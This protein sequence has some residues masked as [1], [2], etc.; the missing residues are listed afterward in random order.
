MICIVESA[1]DL[2]LERER[3]RLLLDTH[4]IL[5]GELQDSRRTAAAGFWRPDT[6]LQVGAA[7]QS[8][9]EPQDRIIVVLLLL[10]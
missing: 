7:R 10:G 8:T 2:C 1:C 3:M 4:V 5:G 6:K 9:R